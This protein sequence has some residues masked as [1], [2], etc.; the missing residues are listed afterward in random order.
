MMEQDTRKIHALEEKAH[1]LQA[2]LNFLTNVDRYLGELPNYTVKKRLAF[3][4]AVLQKLEERK[5][6]IGLKS[7]VTNFQNEMQ[8]ARDAFQAGDVPLEEI[9]FS[10]FEKLK[11]FTQRLFDTLKIKIE[12]LRKNGVD[13][14]QVKDEINLTANTLKETSKE[15]IRL[16]RIKN[17][18]YLVCEAPIIPIPS[19]SYFIFENLGKNFRISR[20]QDYPILHEQL[21]VG[22]NRGVTKLSS[23]EPTL[24]EVI[25]KLESRKKTKFIQIASQGAS[26]QIAGRG[27]VW[28]WLMPEEKAELFRKCFRNYGGVGTVGTKALGLQGIA[29][30]SWGFADG[31]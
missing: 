22:I 24:R 2:F 5:I 23:A 17:K 8:S 27:I 3:T 18:P 10:S 29:I 1:A 21:V 11:D 7:H 12:D 6:P 14:S 16:A 20:I 13:M 15:M 4:Q 25:K 19:N 26:S 31:S 28:Y 30:R 9:S